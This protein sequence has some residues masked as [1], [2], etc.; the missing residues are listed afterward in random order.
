MKNIW[1]NRPNIDELVI[2]IK[3][4][5]II[6]SS[7]LEIFKLQPSMQPWQHQTS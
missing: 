4:S 3:G 1:K 5:I 7:K 6:S 2:Q